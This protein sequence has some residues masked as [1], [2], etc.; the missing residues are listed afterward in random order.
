M[1]VRFDA[2]KKQHARPRSLDS[3]R[4]ERSPQGT[5]NDGRT[6]QAHDALLCHA[7]VNKEGRPIKSRG[8]R[9]VWSNPCERPS[10]GP[11]GGARSSGMYTEP[12]E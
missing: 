6:N 10:A 2:A 8:L 1:S 5:E 9:V 12:G 3:F 11:D 7:D 4:S